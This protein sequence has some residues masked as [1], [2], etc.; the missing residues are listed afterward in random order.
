MKHQV[1]G[2]LGQ[3]GGLAGHILHSRAHSLHPDGREVCCGEEGCSGKPSASSRPRSAH[4]FTPLSAPSSSAPWSPHPPSPGGRTRTPAHRGLRGPRP[5]LF[6]LL[7]CRG[8][9]KRKDDSKQQSPVVVTINN[10]GFACP[11]ASIG[12]A[13]CCC[14]GVKAAMDNTHLDTPDA[15][16]R[17]LDAPGCVTASCT[18][19]RVWTCC[20]RDATLRPQ[21]SD[22]GPAAGVVPIENEPGLPSY[23]V[24]RHLPNTCR[25]RNHFLGVKTLR[26]AMEHIQS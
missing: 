4:V 9:R 6:I 13:Q 15:R 5:R 3:M 2:P 23:L 14:C 7:F 17:H 22:P 1:P 12:A 10:L 24:E 20:G 21:R 11:L 19:W 18:T 25:V 16:E 8:P 26:F